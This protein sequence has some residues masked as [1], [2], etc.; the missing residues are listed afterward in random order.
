MRNSASADT[1]QTTMSP[2]FSSAA[3]SRESSASKTIAHA[4]TLRIT[5]VPI[6]SSHRYV[7]PFSAPGLHDISAHGPRL[8]PFDELGQITLALAR[9][10]LLDL[11]AD[12]RDVAVVLDVA[13]D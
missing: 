9:L 12:E 6:V 8:V 13:E 7:S 5:K 1:S 3:V 4:R 10:R 11:L 2:C